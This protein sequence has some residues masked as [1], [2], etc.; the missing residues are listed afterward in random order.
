MAE[1]G[2]ASGPSLLLRENALLAVAAPR[3]VPINRLFLRVCDGFLISNKQ[4]VK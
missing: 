3:P 4:Y 1:F 2:Q